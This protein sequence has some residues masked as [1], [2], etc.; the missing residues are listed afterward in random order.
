MRSTGREIQSLGCCE[1]DLAGVWITISRGTVM[2]SS[3]NTT[4]HPTGVDLAV[5]DHGSLSPS[6]VIQSNRVIASITSHILAPLSSL[7]PL[8][9]S[10]AL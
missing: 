8:T 5:H 4:F 2:L 9:V 6:L 7:D 3:A 10:A 1:E